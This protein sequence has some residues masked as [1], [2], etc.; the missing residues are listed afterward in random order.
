MRK[1]KVLGITLGWG[2]NPQLSFDDNTIFYSSDC[3]YIFYPEYFP[4]GPNTWP[5]DPITK[6][7]LEIIKYK[8]LLMW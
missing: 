4:D 6:E 5:K 7:K 2:G 8:T 1:S 3:D